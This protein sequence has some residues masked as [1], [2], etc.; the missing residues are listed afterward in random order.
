[1]FPFPEGLC[2]EDQGLWSLAVPYG[3][4]RDFFYSGH[5][6]FIVF[7][8]QS[9]EYPLAK[10]MASIVLVYV[11]A[12]LLIA[13]VHYTIDVVGGA[14]FSIL[15]YRL[16]RNNIQKCDRVVSQVLVGIAAPLLRVYQA[17]ANH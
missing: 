3:R 13:R 12:L 16:V 1:M 2:W 5:T 14:L 8:I 11:V 4:A 17:A 6:G 7:F 9:V 15:F 10:A